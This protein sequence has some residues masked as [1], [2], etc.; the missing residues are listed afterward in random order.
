ME[1]TLENPNEP[2]N[3]STKHKYYFPTPL[4]ILSLLSVEVVND[5]NDQDNNNNVNNDNNSYI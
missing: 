2:D 3:P 1:I 4:G 5:N